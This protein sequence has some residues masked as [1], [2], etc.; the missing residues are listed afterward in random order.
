MYLAWKEIRYAKLRYSLIIG[1]MVLVA[2]V[3]LMLSGLANG[4]SDGHKKAV[5]DW[6]AQTIVLSEDSNKVAS[7]SILTRGDLSRVE[8]KEKAAVGLLLLQSPI[9]EKPKRPIS[10]SLVLRPINSLSQK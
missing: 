3:V 6:G 8:A 1:I 7:A 9:K 2:Y 5:A 4:L 10:P